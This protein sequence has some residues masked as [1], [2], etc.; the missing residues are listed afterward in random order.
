MDILFTFQI[1]I[2]CF[3]GEQAA[4]SEA[5]DTKKSKHK[6]ADYTSKFIYRGLHAYPASYI[7]KLING[8]Y[9]YIQLNV[10]IS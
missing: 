5:V 2:L 10:L 7:N 8:G 3:I 1:L 9:I 6:L 4:P